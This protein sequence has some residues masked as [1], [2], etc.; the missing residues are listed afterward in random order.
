M[1]DRR[2]TVE[3]RT[4]ARCATA[5]LA[6]LILVDGVAST[7]TPWR[8]VL[9]L[10]LAAL[11]FLVLCPPRISAGPGWLATRCLLRTRR[12][13]TDLLVSVYPHDGVSRRLVL[14]DAL[15]GRVELDPQ[16]FLD[17]PG[18]WY[19]VEE[20]IL[21]STTTGSL[22]CGTTALHRLTEHVDRETARTVFKLSGLD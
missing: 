16:V 7:L 10:A 13:R 4:A 6:L 17:N 21:H 22:R 11:L 20:D 5:L 3:V 2:W 19:R 14:R 8:G 15:G 12:V 9:W 18:L 1:Y